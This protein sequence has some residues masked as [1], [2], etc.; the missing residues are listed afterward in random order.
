MGKRM[1]WLAALTLLAA[2]LAAQDRID[3]NI[4]DMVIKGSPIFQKEGKLELG[5]DRTGFGLDWTVLSIGID[6]NVLN[7]DRHKETSGFLDSVAAAF[8]GVNLGL[9]EVGVRGNAAGR[10]LFDADNDILFQL[11]AG[12]F[13]RKQAR[14]GGEIGFG[15]SADLVWQEPTYYELTGPILRFD[16][17]RRGAIVGRAHFAYAATDYFGLELGVFGSNS[18][19]SEENLDTSADYWEI[20]FDFG[21]WMRFWEF[22]QIKPYIRGEYDWFRDAFDQNDDGSFSGED[23]LQLLKGKLAVEIRTRIG[24]LFGMVA[25]VYLRRQDDSAQG[26]Q[27]YWQYGFDAAALFNIVM[28]RVTVGVKG[29]SREYTD[30]VDFNDIG[31]GETTFERLFGIW[32]EVRANVIWKL[33]VG[34]R[35]DFDRR[36]SD[37]DNRGYAN[38]QYQL[39]AGLSF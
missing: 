38:G 16:K 23:K 36:A 1:L 19:F 20:G 35:A 32:A 26:F 13:V 3:G 27:R 34:V 15:V 7:V 8:F 17:V 22:L 33:Y 28:V 14:K 6:D 31:E 2:P 9:V 4:E 30:A 37:F 18:D 39:F 25:N 12:G 10:I 29:W 11:N 5:Q 24:S 21:L